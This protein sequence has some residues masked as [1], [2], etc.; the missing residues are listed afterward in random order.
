MV[1]LR[2]V[3]L[4]LSASDRWFS[5]QVVPY[6]AL[7]KHETCCGHQPQ[8][9]SG[10]QSSMLKKDL[11][12]HE[13]LCPLIEL[14]CADC[15]LV[16]KRRDTTMFHTDL[17]CLKEQLQHSQE[18]NQQLNEQIKQNLLEHEKELKKLREEYEE[19]TLQLT[20]IRTLWRKSNVSRL[21]F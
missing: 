19:R 18:K 13:I 15:Q 20:G 21:H 10:C 9:C 12:E 4:S 2:S 11:I 3:V 8:Q 14:T 17:I 1:A 7:H 16:Y 6:E 5:L